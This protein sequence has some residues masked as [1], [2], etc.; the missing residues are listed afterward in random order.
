MECKVTLEG[1]LIHSWR[2]MIRFHRIKGLILFLGKRSIFG[3]FFKVFYSVVGYFGVGALG[4]T[5]CLERGF[6]L[7][8][9]GHW[10]YE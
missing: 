2:G 10:L 1:P 9:C 4:I 7:S 8:F 6:V 3:K 5:K